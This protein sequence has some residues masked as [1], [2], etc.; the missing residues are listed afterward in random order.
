MMYVLN[1][2]SFQYLFLKFY[3]YLWSEFGKKKKKNTDKSVYLEALH[4][5]LPFRSS[6]RVKAVNPRAATNRERR[7]I[8]RIRYRIRSN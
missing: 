6:D 5:V 1:S 3:Q 4:V 7:L 2:S 8:E